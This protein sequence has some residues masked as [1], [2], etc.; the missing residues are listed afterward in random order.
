MDSS[1]KKSPRIAPWIA[2]IGTCVAI[3]VLLGAW[4]GYR[5]W[6]ARAAAAR[7]GW[8]SAYP[9]GIA[10]GWTLERHP[11]EYVMTITIANISATTVSDYKLTGIRLG[12]VT[13]RPDRSKLGTLA[14]HARETV[15]VHFPG[16]R[17]SYRT[18]DFRYS[19][20]Y[21]QRAMTTNSSSATLIE[22]P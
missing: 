10:P 20:N 6:Q 9:V 13:G 19:Q 3:L 21:K 8:R 11:G 22:V 7:P 1:I 15:R 18:V 2:L 16:L 14:S 17:K 4:T 5:W 12:G